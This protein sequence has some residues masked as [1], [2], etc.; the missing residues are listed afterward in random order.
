M[1]EVFAGW[2]R[3]AG[4]PLAD[5][6][7]APTWMV[8]RTARQRWTVALSGDG[9]DELLG[10]Y[11]RLKLMA[12]LED[13]RRAPGVVRTILP[14]VLPARRWVAKLASA[15]ACRERWGAYQA[16][17]GVWPAAEAARLCGLEEAPP[18][19]PPELLARLDH[20]PSWLR[21]RLLD[22]LSF[23][24]DRMLAKVDRASMHHGLEVR[25]PLLDHRVVEFLLSL[26]PGLVRGKR[27]L[28]GAIDR[29]GAPPPP[30]RKRG[31]EVP[32]AGWLRGPL[33]GTIEGSLF[34]PTARRLG[35]DGALLRTAW[36]THQDGRADLGERLLAVAV[37]VRWVEEWA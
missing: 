4:D 8:S 26:P 20:Q 13:W 5:P 2:P 30:R 12:H 29:L 37:L 24:P 16:L 7:L 31:F 3:I 6:S 9:G 22:M 35:L 1:L 14:M 11:P 27:V 15:L 32:L 10:G 18:V 33:R 23:L 28:R 25:V 36:T 34:G 17:Q 21:Y 19:W